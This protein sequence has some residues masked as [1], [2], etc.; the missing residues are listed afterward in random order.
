MQW[1]FSAFTKS[2]QNA[3]HVLSCSV[4]FS[5]FIFSYL[6]LLGGPGPGSTRDVKRLSMGLFLE[7]FPF[8]GVDISFLQFPNVG[9]KLA[10]RVTFCNALTASF[11]KRSVSLKVHKIGRSLKYSHMTI[12]ILSLGSN[13]VNFPHFWG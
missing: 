6:I 9:T 11:C 5:Y 13:I 2:S 12:I 10:V 7:H 3:N 1:F 4:F 8:L